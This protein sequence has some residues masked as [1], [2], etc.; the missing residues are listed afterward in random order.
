MKGLAVYQEEKEKERLKI[1]ELINNLPHGSGING[2]WFYYRTNR[3]IYMEN[4]YHAMNE[5]GMYCHIYDFR[6][7]YRRKD[8]KLLDLKVFGKEFKCCGYGL[9]EYLDQLFFG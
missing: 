5:V 2:D 7:I 1:L 3:R 9:R 4:Y 8:F 6:L